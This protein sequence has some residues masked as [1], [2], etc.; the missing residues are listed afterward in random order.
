[1]GDL[2]NSLD[3]DSW[4]KDRAPVTLLL[5]SPCQHL[6]QG[7]H[8]PHMSFSEH[9]NT[10]V[11]HSLVFFLYSTPRRTDFGGGI[12]PPSAESPILWYFFCKVSYGLLLWH[13]GQHSLGGLMNMPFCAWNSF[14]TLEEW[15]ANCSNGTWQFVRYFPKKKIKRRVDWVS[16]FKETI[17]DVWCPPSKQNLYTTIRLSEKNLSL[18]FFLCVNVLFIVIQNHEFLKLCNEIYQLL[19]ELQDS[20]NTYFSKWPIQDIPIP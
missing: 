7:L 20:V 11:Q 9:I 15:Q 14:S 10:P 12:G 18:P 6:H 2:L 4:L 1:M 3:N 5:S 17:A 13:E 19:E 16:Y 8:F